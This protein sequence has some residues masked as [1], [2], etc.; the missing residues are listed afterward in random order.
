MVPPWLTHW[1]ALPCPSPA[2]TD[3]MDEP[4]LEAPGGRSWGRS[5]EMTSRECDPYGTFEVTL[6]TY[7]LIPTKGYEHLGH[8]EDA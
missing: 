6:R 1:D 2:P 5:F 4:A 7:P 8:L 3:M